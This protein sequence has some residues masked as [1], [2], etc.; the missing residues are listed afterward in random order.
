MNDKIVVGC[1]TCNTF[2]LNMKWGDYL[3]LLNGD[4]ST[5]TRWYNKVAKHYCENP[6]HQIMSNRN[7]QGFNESFDF[8]KQFRHQL[9]L[10]NLSIRDFE[11]AVDDTAQTTEF[12][13]I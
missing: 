13:P 7:P 5:P 2:F 11:L 3:P 6:T 9:T 4:F 10:N 12:L 8:T 1:V